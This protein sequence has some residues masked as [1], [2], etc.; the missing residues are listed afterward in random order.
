MTADIIKHPDGSWCVIGH[1]S[2]GD[3]CCKHILHVRSEFRFGS[4]VVNSWERA[5]V[6]SV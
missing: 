5:K 1:L 3:R 6:A 4:Q 2:S